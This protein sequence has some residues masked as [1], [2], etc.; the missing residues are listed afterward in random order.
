MLK[1]AWVVAAIS[2]FSHVQ[3]FSSL[4]RAEVQREKNNKRFFMWQVQLLLVLEVSPSVI[5]THSKLAGN[6]AQ[7]SCNSANRVSLRSLF[8]AGLF[9]LL[10][11]TLSAL[12][13]WPPSVAKR[14][15]KRI[16]YSKEQS[17]PFLQ[18]SGEELP[19]SMSWWP[20]LQP[21]MSSVLQQPSCPLDTV[22]F[23]ER[24]MRSERWQQMLPLKE[25][26]RAAAFHGP[27]SI[28]RGW[29]VLKGSWA[30]GSYLTW[31]LPPGKMRAPHQ[32]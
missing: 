8:F 15:A 1:S 19:V 32:E 3:A 28:L 10:G 4:F 5:L 29:G 14:V 20:G 6:A 23:G 30:T 9:P 27:W 7:V 13:F 22:R 11:V 25:C 17:G 12:C 18:W 24:C 31:G 16:Q 21:E 2:C 26:K